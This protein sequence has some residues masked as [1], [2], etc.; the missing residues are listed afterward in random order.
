M[1]IIDVTLVRVYLAEREGHLDEV[2]ECLRTAGVHGWTVYRGV[3]GFGQ[4]GKV[5]GASLVDLSLDLPV[6][7]EFFD[8]AA[9]LE[10]VL[11]EL[12]R[13]AG[14]GHVVWWAAQTTG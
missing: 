12:T 8:I 9:N 1:N 14:K 4:S 6:T 7:V 5:R 13:I 11:G 10:G 2:L 3:S